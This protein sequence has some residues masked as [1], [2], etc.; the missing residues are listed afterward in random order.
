MFCAVLRKLASYSLDWGRGGRDLRGIVTLDI[1]VTVP[2]VARIYDWL[3][4]GTF[5]FDADRAAADELVLT[6]PTVRELALNS[7]WFLERAVRSLVAERGFRQ[8]LELGAGLPNRRN[9]HQI[10][11]AVDPL[12]RVVYVDNDPVVIAYGRASLDENDRTALIE[13]DVT[14]TERVFEHPA[15]RELIREGEPTAALM[16]SLLDCVPDR[17]GPAELVQRVARRLAPGSVIVICQAVSDDPAMASAFTES[18]LQQTH[19]RWG[20]V[21][22]TVDVKR[23]FAGLDIQEPG[24]VDVSDWC[25]DSEIHQN[26]RS[27][28][29]FAF[30][31]LAIV[32]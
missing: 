8:F 29:C 30:G 1:D 11:Q 6:L 14:D 9:V 24:L 10:A 13:A 23:F 7:R 2:S 17:Q 12:A 25:P 26:M 20:M 31:G 28:D 22:G 19:G 4:G 16:V 5:N 32:R 3:T 21:R 18:I 27:V 15:V